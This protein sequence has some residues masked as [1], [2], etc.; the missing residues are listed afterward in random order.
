[1]K[2]TALWDIAP[3]VS[4]KCTDVSEVPTASIIR[5]D[6]EGSHLHSK[7]AVLAHSARTCFLPALVL[8]LSNAQRKTRDCLNLYTEPV[9]GQVPYF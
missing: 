2:M 5:A 4:L 7:G 9:Q 8:T 1:M 6:D 3:C